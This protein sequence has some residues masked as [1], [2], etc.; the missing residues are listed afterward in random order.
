MHE[1]SLAIS[2]MEIV[3][4][5]ARKLDKHSIKAIEIE[6]GD[7]AGVELSSFRFSM[8]AVIRASV[9]DKAEVR[10]ISIQA[11]AECVNCRI[12]FNAPSRFCCCPQ[13]KDYCVSLIQ[14]TEFRLTAIIFEDSPA[15]TVK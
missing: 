15:P 11:I 9:F 8:E 7:F 6:V 1:L 4:Q 10:L 12:S 5:E 2:V 3:V 14:G 13:C